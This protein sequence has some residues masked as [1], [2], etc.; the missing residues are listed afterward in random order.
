MTIVSPPG[1]S[2]IDTF[3][4][5]K[6]VL[7]PFTE[8]L[9]DFV[10]DISKSI[11]KDKDF[12]EHPEILALAFW[13]RKSHIQKL[14]VHFSQLQ[15]E[16]IFL[17]RGVIFHLAPSNVDTIFVY[18]WLISLLVGNSNIVRLSAK[19]N[20]QTEL[21]LDTINSI[22]AQKKYSILCERVLILQYGH[23]D[24]I[25]KK[26][27]LMADTRVIWGGDQTIEHIRMLPIKATATELTFA[28][29]FSF[30]LIKSDELLKEQN[31]QRLI[32]NFYNDAFSFSQMA[33]SSIRLIA[34]VGTE[35][36]NHKAKKIFWKALGSY[37]LQKAPTEITPADIVN[38]L[39]A[40]C[41]IAIESPIKIEKNSNP[42]INKI[43]ISR[44]TEVKED[45]HCGTG[46]FYELET[47]DLISI[48]QDINKK[49]QTVSHYGFNPEELKQ[50]IYKTLPSGIDRIVP[51]GKSLEFSHIWDGTD[52][53]QSFCRE[54]D[55][56]N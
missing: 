31:L 15:G 23:E 20:L 10:N 1:I 36:D 51:I 4:I 5:N 48:F 33:C 19:K 26:L 28:D 35:K 55:L 34:W 53:L 40:E 6:S 54:V 50:A 39:V 13:M 42:Y 37:T 25:T 29:K 7:I 47:N 24:E 43:N 14:K 21:L 45:L 30:A 41:S 17:G 38:K 32:R 49:H 11:L 22:L 16:K 3:S 8:I 9:V 12:K 44:L 18:S 46:L 27:S 52:L 2:S 56:W